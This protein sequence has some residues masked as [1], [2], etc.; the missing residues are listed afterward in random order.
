M[1]IALWTTQSSRSVTWPGVSV[2]G[3]GDSPGPQRRPFQVTEK[4][5]RVLA[6]EAF[7]T[8]SSTVGV[9]SAGRQDSSVQSTLLVAASPTGVPSAPTFDVQ[10]NRIASPRGS[11]T[12]TLNVT[13]SPASAL[14]ADCDGVV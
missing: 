9:T 13:R 5:C 6:P 7:V 10:A 14:V 8:T 4:E 12:F 2:T 11:D 3:Q 1:N